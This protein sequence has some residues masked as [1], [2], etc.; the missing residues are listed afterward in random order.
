MSLGVDRI[1]ASLPMMEETA[2]GS[3]HARCATPGKH[4]C[5]YLLPPL[6]QAKGEQ[7]VGGSKEATLL[8]VS[9]VK[10]TREWMSLQNVFLVSAG[11]KLQTSLCKYF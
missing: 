9:Y 8:S 4:N 10:T 3:C 2:R 6:H 5:G 1:P 7:K 11:K